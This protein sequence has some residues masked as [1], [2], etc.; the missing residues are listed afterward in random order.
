MRPNLIVIDGPKGAGKTT[1]ALRLVSFLND[2]SLSHGY[3]SVTY[4]KHL[5]DPLDETGNMLKLITTRSSKDLV[6]IDRFC[7]TEWVMGIYTGRVKPTG[8]TE[9]SRIIDRVLQMNSIPHLLLL[10]PL[11]LLQERLA[12]RAEEERRKVDMPWELVHP[13]WNA[14]YGQGNMVLFK[15]ASETDAKEILNYLLWTIEY[16]G[17]QI[18]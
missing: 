16:R 4:H 7:W 5:R 6:I 11:N 17:D 3:E 12:N 18:A 13:L 15:N 10:P 14:A 2:H 1:V 8:L 9:S